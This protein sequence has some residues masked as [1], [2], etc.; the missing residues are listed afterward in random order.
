MYYK[1]F[2]FGECNCIANMVLILILLTLVT[3]TICNLTVQ[4]VGI[5]HLSNSYSEQIGGKVSS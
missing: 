4:Y 2:Y 3:D 1:A 5:D